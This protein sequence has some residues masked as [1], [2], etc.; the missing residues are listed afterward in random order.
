VYLSNDLS[1]SIAFAL[2]IPRLHR[3]FSQPFPLVHYSHFLL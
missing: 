1:T 2:I 3:G